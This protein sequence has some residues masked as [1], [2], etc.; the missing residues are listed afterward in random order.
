M[1]FPFT[2][3]RYL[4]NR[5]FDLSCVDKNGNTPLHLIAEANSVDSISLVLKLGGRTDLV[6]SDGLT[7]EALATQLGHRKAASAIAR[8]RPPRNSKPQ[9]GELWF[10][11]PWIVP[12]F[13]DGSVFAT[14]L[15]SNL[16][17]VWAGVGLFWAVFFWQFGHRLLPK[18]GASDNSPFAYAHVITLLLLCG[19]SY[20]FL[21]AL[22]LNGPQFLSLHL[23]F[24]ILAVICGV[25]FYQCTR[26]DPGF[27]DKKNSGLLTCTSVSVPDYGF[28]ESCFIVR[29]LRSKHCSTCNRCVKVFDHHCPY[30]NNC[31]GRNNMLP[32]F[33]FLLSSFSA[34]PLYAV[35]ASYFLA[36]GSIR[37]LNI[38]RVGFW[39]FIGGYLGLHFLFLGSLVLA[40]I[41]RI[42]QNRTTAERI[43]QKI[44]PHRYVYLKETDKG[45]CSNCASFACSSCRAE[46][47]DPEYGKST[48]DAF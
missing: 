31:V 46:I 35:A 18:D 1:S 13:L 8:F 12:P 4:H 24:W 15:F 43:N 34:L 47:H 14:L 44:N 40:Q 17:A 32:F 2:A 9:K 10:Y 48:A 33:L 22:H 29:P 39:V 21:F 45:V 23:S 20:F 30:V 26:S 3:V 7:P 16:Y 19:I 41:Q 42:L 6:N 27:C 25:C 36:P 38:D 28:C 11:L 37:V 5:G